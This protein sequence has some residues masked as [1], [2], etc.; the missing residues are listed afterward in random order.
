[1]TIDLRF[2][3]KLYHAL[4]SDVFV[5]KGRVYKLFKRSVDPSLD[6]RALTL[7]EAQCD[8]F[9]RAANDK[10]M[11]QHTPVF[12]GPCVIE[13]VIGDAGKN[14]SEGYRLNNCY[15]LEQLSGAELKVND[16]EIREKYPHVANV[17]KHF[18]SFGINTGDASVFRYEDPE[19]FKLIDITTRAF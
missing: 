2:H 18:E 1:M 19:G 7:F 6:S 13:D 11:T 14:V 15:A 16:Q 9:T 5:V 8:A 3:K 4:Y 17:R 10:V 12:Y